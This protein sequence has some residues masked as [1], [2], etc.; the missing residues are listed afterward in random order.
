MRIC[1]I[2]PILLFEIWDP[3]SKCNIIYSNS[4]PPCAVLHPG[5][6]VWFGMHLIANETWAQLKERHEGFVYERK[7]E[8]KD[9]VYK[10]ADWMVR[11]YSL[12]GKIVCSSRQYISRSWRSIQRQPSSHWLTESVVFVISWPWARYYRFCLAWCCRPLLRGE[13]VWIPLGVGIVPIWDSMHGVC[14]AC[15]HIWNG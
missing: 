7:M 2:L 5:N 9:C 10:R 11:G 6:P 13:G 1:W 8:V 12:S 15:T 14:T 3:I 4:G